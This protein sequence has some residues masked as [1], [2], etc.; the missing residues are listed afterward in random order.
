MLKR[1]DNLTDV[2]EQLPKAP[3]STPAQSS[4]DQQVLNPMG[5]LVTLGQEKGKSNTKDIQGYSLELP[6]E[7]IKQAISNAFDEVAKRQR[8]RRNRE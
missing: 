6:T 8:E 4:N 3:V 2:V 7:Q 1:K 5:E